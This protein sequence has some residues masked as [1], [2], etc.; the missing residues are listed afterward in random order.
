MVVEADCFPTCCSTEYTN[1]QQGGNKKKDSLLVGVVAVS[2]DCVDEFW[3]ILEKVS[4]GEGN[5]RCEMRTKRKANKQREVLVRKAT[6][7][8]K[9]ML[10]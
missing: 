4:F 7:T 1:K 3:A 2:C 9:T 10:A 8:V 5:K 6:I